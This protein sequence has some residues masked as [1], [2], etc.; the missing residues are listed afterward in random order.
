MQVSI[1]AE[2]QDLEE[3]AKPVSN[4]IS[5]WIKATGSVAIFVDDRNEEGEDDGEFDRQGTGNL[6]IKINIRK[7]SELRDP[8]KKLYAIATK[9]KLEFV[10]GLVDEKTGKSE[11]V[12]Y[13][14]KEEGVPDVFEIA[15]YLGLK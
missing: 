13:F 12:C 10:V 4:A 7:K 15:N 3:V 11:E 5:Q 14:G 6:G 1:Y 2:H 9:H 8:L